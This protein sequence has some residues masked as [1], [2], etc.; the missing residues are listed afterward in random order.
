MR[1]E[2]LG[3]GEA[4]DPDQPN[5]S[6]LV[7]HGG[8]TLLIDCGHSVIPRLWRAR[9]D[10]EAVDAIYFTH[11]HADHVL[12][13]PSVLDCWHYGGRRRKLLIVTTAPGIEQ[14]RQLLAAL[15]VDTRYELE[16]AVSAE[17]DAIGPFAVRTALTDHAAPNYAIR[18]EA[19]GR[20]FAHSGDGRPTPESRALYA[21]AD[22]LLHECYEPRAAP[23]MTFHCD[24]PTVRTIAGPPRIGLYHIHA[25]MRGAMRDAIAGDPRLFVP[26]AGDVLEV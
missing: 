2:L 3:V 6:A 8:F 21:D 19:G 25:G 7:E 22:L 9:P 12:G 1:I 17:I 18:L 13:L 11:H 23:E 26:E 10:P 24:L 20:R 16:F 14:L 15:R 5:S 4:F